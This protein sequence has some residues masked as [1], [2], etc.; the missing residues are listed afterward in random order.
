MHVT[1]YFDGMVW[2]RRWPDFAS[3]LVA[4]DCNQ[5]NI[6]PQKKKKNLPADG[7]SRSS[8]R[9]CLLNSLGTILADPQTYFGEKNSIYTCHN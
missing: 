9:K 6:S 1:S 7:L 2:L 4:S 5:H 8:H 3:Y